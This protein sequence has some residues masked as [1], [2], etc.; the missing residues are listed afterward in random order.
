MRITHSKISRRCPNAT[1]SLLSSHL[2]Q[3]DLLLEA[4]SQNIRK[5]PKY[6][7][8]DMAIYLAIVLLARCGMRINEPLRVQMITIVA[9]EGTVY[10]EK[11]K[12]RK[13]RLIPV[14][15]SHWRRSKI[16]WPCEPRF[17]PKTKIHIFWPAENND[18]SETS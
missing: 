10:I 3:T 5:S 9:D 7:L 6:F 1:L 14:P 16:T 12:F 13:D 17:A 18:G 11:T 15:K 4:V 8:T 2:A